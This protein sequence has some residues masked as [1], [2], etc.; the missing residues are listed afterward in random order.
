MEVFNNALGHTATG[1]NKSVNGKRSKDIVNAKADIAKAVTTMDNVVASVLALDFE[2]S[3]RATN[4]AKFDLLRKPNTKTPTNQHD[5]VYAWT[6][7]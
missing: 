6:Q 2:N 3:A 1:D 4:I 5:A 7:K